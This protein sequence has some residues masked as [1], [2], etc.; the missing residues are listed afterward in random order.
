MCPS[1]TH[2]DFFRNHT[3]I[4]TGIIPLPWKLTQEQQLDRLHVEG[5]VF[6]QLALNVFVPPASFR[7]ILPSVHAGGTAHLLGGTSPEPPGSNALVSDLLFILE[8]TKG[9]RCVPS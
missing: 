9:D 1:I 7:A 8:A 6:I 4:R 2:T 3:N 5:F